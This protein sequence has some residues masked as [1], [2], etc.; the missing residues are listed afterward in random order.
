M[1]DTWNLGALLFAC[2]EGKPPFDA[3]NGLDT[4]AAVV[5]DPVPPHPNSGPLGP[6]ISG[7]LVKSPSLRM[8][9]P[10]ALT[11]LQQSADDP[12]GTHLR[13]PIR[14]ERHAVVTK[15]IS[16]GE[17]SSSLRGNTRTV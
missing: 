14:R 6:V 2:V 7:L 15:P 9:T 12:S 5:N 16:A 1:S 3:G 13:T 17:A 10:Q 11:R 4:V 8:T